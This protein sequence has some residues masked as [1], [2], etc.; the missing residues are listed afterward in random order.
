MP[1][2]RQQ[3]TAV[4]ICVEVGHVEGR[5]EMM[6]VG[7]TKENG[8]TATWPGLAYRYYNKFNNVL[9]ED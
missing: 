1:L 4:E 5:R 2:L 3:R 6:M 8:A 9:Q 7:V